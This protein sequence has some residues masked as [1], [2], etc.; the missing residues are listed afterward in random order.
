M[1]QSLWQPG[2]TATNALESRTFQRNRMN[3]PAGAQNP[4]A[5]DVARRAM[6]VGIGRDA[7]GNAVPT[8]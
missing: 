1:I 2:N 4:A 7:G 6:A 3:L 5:L 8:F